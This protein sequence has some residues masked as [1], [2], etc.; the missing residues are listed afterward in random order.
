M[1]GD[2]RQQRVV[3]GDIRQQQET[4]RF[5]CSLCRRDDGCSHSSMAEC[6]YS[7]YTANGLCRE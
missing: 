6:T 2:I 3:V 7:I 1:V 4:A 5:S